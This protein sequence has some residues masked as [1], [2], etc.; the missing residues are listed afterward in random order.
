MSFS[1]FMTAEFVYACLLFIAGNVLGWYASNL[2]FVSEFW[3]GKM[4]LP[5]LV[6]GVPSMIC[7]WL[8][9]KYA[10]SSVQELW[11]V[12]FLGAALSYLT[13]P[14]MTWYY[15]G[16]SM[17]SIKTLLCVFLAMCILA[18]QVFLK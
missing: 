6:F 9:S 2:Q 5:I 16:E 13:F 12:R 1:S 18:I 11:T 17:L 14:I 8:G 10:M 15:I 7:F 4:I 3:K